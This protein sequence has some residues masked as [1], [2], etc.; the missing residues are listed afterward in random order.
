MAVVD[1]FAALSN[2]I[3]GTLAGEG[4]GVVHTRST[5]TV[6]V[7]AVVDCFAM[8]TNPIVRTLAGERVRVVDTSSTVAVDVMTVVYLTT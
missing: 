4:V 8:L 2:P 3:T 5:V 7:V 6:D 1:C